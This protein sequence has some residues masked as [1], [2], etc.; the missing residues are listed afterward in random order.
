MS[1]EALDATSVVWSPIGLESFPQVAVAPRGV[2]GDS[3]HR[4]HRFTRALDVLGAGTGL[5]LASPLI[6]AV[7][8]LIRVSSRGPVVF[9]HR[10]LG[11]DVEPFAC[12][13]FRTM[14]R[15][16]DR[17]VEELRRTRP[18]IDEEL[19]SNF[20]LRDDPRITRLG[21]FLRRTSL[22]E[23]PQ[24]LNVLR[25]EMSLVGPRP[26]VAEEGVKY[27]PQ[28]RRVLSVRPGMTGAWQV[29]GRNRIGYPD[30]VDIDVEY[31]NRKS[32][33]VDISILMK[34]PAAIFDWRAT[35]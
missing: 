30:R 16:A 33:F 14:H 27:G 1:A 32:L 21:R 15:D 7:A 26:I 6:V 3:S 13:K 2:A 23:L 20:K 24:L 22:D 18:D 34:T 35:S 8:A 19:A 28:L 11:K 31:V 17:I 9:R 12:L 5:I 29:A 4:R 10:R 25:G